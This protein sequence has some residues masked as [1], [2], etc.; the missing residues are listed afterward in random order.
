[1]L[2]MAV[3][4]AARL[5]MAQAQP[6]PPSAPADPASAARHFLWQVTAPSGQQAYLVGS[7]HVLS[8]AFYPLSPALDEAFAASN[9]LVEEVDLD[10]TRNPATMMA[11][12]GMAMLPAGQSIEQLVS[13]TTYEALRARAER[14]GVPIAL[15][16][17]MKPW[18]AAVTLT[19]AQLNA[20]GF[21]GSLGIDQHFFDRAKVAGMPRRALETA[22]YQF[23]RLD[24][25]PAPLQ[26]VALEALLTDA[27]T[28]VSSITEIATAWRAGDV[29]TIERLL[30]EGFEKAPQLA[31]RLLHE[32]NRNWIPHVERCLTEDA[33]CFIVVG[34]A[35]LVG[36][37]SV[38]ELL[39]ARG[40]RVEQK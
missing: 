32:R 2:T 36:P 4:A 8:K 21:D 24:G 39:R 15:L 7:V 16:Q 22:A 28:Q 31:E 26:E 20:A 11:L 29:A 40:Y 17:R 1:M 33:R 18:M 27:D 37:G 23:E 30:T 3:L 13:K 9:V 38:V 10:E 25:L 12:A 14:Q 19:A 34:A 6:V 5:V 35:H